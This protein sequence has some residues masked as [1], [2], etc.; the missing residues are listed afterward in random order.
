MT[1]DSRPAAADA[2]DPTELAG[3]AEAETQS[4][5][6]W[7][8]D[9]GV[10]EDYP[11]RRLTP[12]RITVAAVVVSLAVVAGAAAVVVMHL[13]RDD[14]APTPA[15]APTSTTPAAVTTIIVA[16]PPPPPPPATVTVQAAPTTVT[17][18]P[19]PEPYTPDWY[20]IYDRRLYNS[21]TARGI[22]ITDPALMAQD[23][24][25]MCARLIDGQSVAGVTQDYA[26]ASRGNYA[27]ATVFVSTVMATYP[28]CP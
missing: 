20:A 3:A 10:I 15:A 4:K 14:P 19:S 28:K 17:Q 6:A 9:D 5:Y 12:R 21:L 27:V 24:H 23:A 16:P 1:S 18:D 25:L 8:L 11:T 2:S 26:A 7:S 22:S 13:R